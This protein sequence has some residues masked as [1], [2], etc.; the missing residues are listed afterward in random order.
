[1][2]FNVFVVTVVVV[3]LIFYK[4]IIKSAETSK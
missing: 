3:L 4:S 2:A 1:M